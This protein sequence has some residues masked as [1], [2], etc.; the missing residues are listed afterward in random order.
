MQLNVFQLN[1]YR[2]Y[3]FMLQGICK[4]I[5]CLYSCI[6]MNEFK[7]LKDI[8]FFLKIF[9]SGGLGKL[10]RQWNLMRILGLE[11]RTTTH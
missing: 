1:K 2:M 4:Y 7:N 11:N 8:F 5:L 3:T 9:L 6:C 10:L